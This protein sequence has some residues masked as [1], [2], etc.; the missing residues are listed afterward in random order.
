MIEEGKGIEVVI[1]TDIVAIFRNENQLF[2][3]EA[4]CAHQ[5]GPLA[6]GKVADGCVTCPWHGWQYELRNGNNAMTCRPMLRTY[7][8]RECEGIVEIEVI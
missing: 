5:G 4:M 2:A 3:L 7:S 8:V 6:Q 1:D